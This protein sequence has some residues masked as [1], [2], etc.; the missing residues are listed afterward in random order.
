MNYSENQ[1]RWHIGCYVIHDADEKSESM[2]MEVIEILDDNKL[3]TKYINREGTQKSY[4]NGVE[5]LHD[6]RRFNIPC[7]GSF[8]CD[9]M[10]ETLKRNWI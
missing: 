7:E 3:R 4:I 1:I 5:V 8:D 10:S 6:P 2:L 9:I